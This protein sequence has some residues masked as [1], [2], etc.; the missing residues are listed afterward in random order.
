MSSTFL[1]FLPPS[2]LAVLPLVSPFLL[3][4]SPTLT[5]SI[6]PLFLNVFLSYVH[7]SCVLFV[8]SVSVSFLRL[9]SLL[10]CFTLVPCFEC[11]FCQVFQFVHPFS[12]ISVFFCFFTSRFSFHSSLLL[13]LFLPFSTWSCNH[14][15]SR[16]PHVFPLSLCFPCVYFVSPKYHSSLIFPSFSERKRRQ[17]HV[18]GILTSYVG[19]ASGITNQIQTKAEFSHAMA[20]TTMVARLE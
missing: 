17:R 19:D 8:S 4:L 2:L 13:R 5:F 14:V 11:G 7:L 10:K 20:V 18:E 15:F 16:V 1:L 6:V 12:T 9:V 3:F